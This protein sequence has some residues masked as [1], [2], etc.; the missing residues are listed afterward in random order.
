MAQDLLQ[1]GIAA[2]QAGDRVRAKELLEQAVAADPENEN[3]WYYLAAAQTHM[4]TRKEYLNRVLAINPNHTR[5][6]EVLARLEA[7]QAPPEPDASEP[8]VKARRAP[9][10]RPLSEARGGIIGEAPEGGFLLPVAIP[11]AP[12]RVDFNSLVQGGSQLIRAGIETL[13]R[14]PGV[15]SS[16]INAA[17]WWRFWLLVGTAA[18]IMSLAAAVRI[19]FFALGGFASI[20]A[21]PL[22]LLLGIPIQMAVFYAGCWASHRYA[23]GQG[24][25]LPLV[26]HSYTIALPYMTGQAIAAVLGA[27]LSVLG[28]GGIGS[29]LGLIIT[30][31]ALYTASF[32]LDMLYSFRD[33]NQR[34]IVLIVFFVAAFLASVLLGVVVGALG[35]GGAIAF[36]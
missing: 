12:L 34:W 6:Q 5:A 1:E 35:V 32:G 3:A 33:G 31:W 4:P 36:L 9:A 18:V 19:L 7:A 30:L 15:Y 25:V 8:P 27:L 2:F 23:Q 17:T 11:D 24:G 14:I 21:V 16:E 29:L 10:L 28:L 22:T 20:L 13:R 26:Q